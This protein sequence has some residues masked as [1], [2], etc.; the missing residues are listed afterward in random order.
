[1]KTLGCLGGALVGCATSVALLCFAIWF[2]GDD[3]LGRD[4]LGYFAAPYVPYI[5][6][7]GAVIGGI[8][9]AKLAAARSARSPRQ[10]A[11][12]IR[13]SRSGRRY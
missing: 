5:A 4:F 8:V 1:M 9:G 11:A 3:A 6:I 10:S 13:Q 12:P 7:I 2:A